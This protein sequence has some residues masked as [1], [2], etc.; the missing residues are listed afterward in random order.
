MQ[1]SKQPIE[2]LRTALQRTYGVD[3]VVSLSDEEVNRIGDL[4]LSVLVESL[5]IQVINSEL[6]IS[7]Q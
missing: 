3:F 6:L 2:D 1:L 4:L 7:Q 5:K